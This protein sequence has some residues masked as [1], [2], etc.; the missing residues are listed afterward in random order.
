M[1]FLI[2]MLFIAAILFSLLTL[3]GSFVSSWSRMVEIIELETSEAS[4]APNIRVGEAIFY[5]APLSNIND[6]VVVPFTITTQDKS[7]EDD[8]AMLEAA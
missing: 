2:S 5:K 7:F 3:S 1:T 6:N 8:I 4:P